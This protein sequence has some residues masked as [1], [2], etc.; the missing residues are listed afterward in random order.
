MFSGL[1]LFGIQLDTTPFHNRPSASRHPN[2]GSERAVQA[3]SWMGRTKGEHD[4]RIPAMANRVCTVS[5][6]DAAGVKHEVEVKAESLLEAAA[7]GLAAMKHEEWVDGDGPGATLEVCV[8]PPVVKHSV[9]VQR[10]MK[11]LDGVTV[12]PAEVLKRKKLK[13]LLRESR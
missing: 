4:A 12:S 11:W 13:A 2:P 6:T 1:S 7:L 9:S 8:T 10:V 5:V 3:P